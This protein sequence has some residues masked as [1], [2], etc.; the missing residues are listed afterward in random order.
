[1]AEFETPHAIVQQRLAC[2]PGLDQQPHDGIP[3]DP[4]EPLGGADRIAFD[5]QVKNGTATVGFEHVQRTNPPQK[6]RVMLEWR[7][8]YKSRIQALT[9][10]DV[11]PRGCYK[12]PR[13]VFH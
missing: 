3:V 8:S 10:P 6:G 4:S 1:M 11:P 5:Q 12:Q 7:R 13:G 2:V 9:R